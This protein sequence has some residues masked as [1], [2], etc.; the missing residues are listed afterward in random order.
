MFT[1]KIKMMDFD[2]PIDP[3]SDSS[4]VK[5]PTVSR[6]YTKIV[7]ADEIEIFDHRPGELFEITGTTGDKKFNCYIA[8]QD[9]PLPKNIYPVDLGTGKSVFG[10]EAYIENASGA[11]TEIV[12]F[13]RSDK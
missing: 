11:T 7:E 3:K 12:K 2:V 6:T 9:K 1:V 8:N 10:Y 5:W 13:P 4:E